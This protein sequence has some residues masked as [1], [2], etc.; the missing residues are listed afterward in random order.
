MEDMRITI[1]F[2]END[3]ENYK[4]AKAQKPNTSV[5]I[6]RLIEQDRLNN[7]NNYL[8]SDQEIIKKLN[9]IEKILRNCSFEAK[10]TNISIEN[11]KKEK[12]LMGILGKQ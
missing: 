1:S 12:A 4:F 3:D 5:Y 6:R 8:N 11:S 2:P 7:E 9:S 10:N